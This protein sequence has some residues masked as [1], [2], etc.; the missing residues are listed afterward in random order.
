[1][2][3][4]KLPDIYKTANVVDVNFGFEPTCDI[5]VE[6]DHYYTLSSGIVSHNTLS[7]MFRDLVMSY[8]VE[9]PF[10]LYYWKRT[11]ISGKYEYYF[12]VP[13]VVIDMYSDKGINIPTQSNTIKDTWSGEKGKPIAEFIENHKNILDLK[14]KRDIDISP[15]DK[16]D[17]MSEL[18]K[19]IDSSI[20]VTY[21]LGENATVKDI[22]D[23][24]I[25]A[26][27]KGL[28][29]IAAFPDKKMYGIVSSMPFKDLAIDLKKQGVQIHN[30]NFTSDELK[31]LDQE[32][33]TFTSAIGTL[34]S[35]EV[36]NVVS[37]RPKVLPADVHHIKISKR[38]DKIRTFE[39]L[40]LVGLID[41][42]PYEVFAFENGQL[43]K[44]YTKGEVIKLARGKYD[45]VLAD[46]IRVENITKGT[47]E[48]ED[49][50]TRMASTCLR[51]GVPVS[52]IVS[53]LEKVEGD[54]FNFSKSIARALKKYIKDGE[55][56]HGF[57]CPGCGK[58]DSLVRQ[59]GCITCAC[60]YSKCG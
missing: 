36:S 43:S 27:K 12:C 6:Q 23:F 54:L 18:M 44:N 20:S 56:V 50:L 14:F 52:F 15:F 53:Q 58:D 11:R 29:S 16:L 34:D 5:E 2:E 49:A 24:I 33:M 26:Y 35:P 22:S 25:L 59:E 41:N 4:V 21:M 45:L 8:G 40:V 42:Q 38:L 57:S 32:L 37:K 51:H 13:Q 7:L 1:M 46:N 3:K 10:G 31:Q 39:Y 28:K 30:Q 17:L 19:S 9:P 47:T 48:S 60:G 55:K